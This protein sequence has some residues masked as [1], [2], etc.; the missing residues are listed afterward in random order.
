MSN[1]F[2]SK[3]SAHCMFVQW[4]PKSLQGWCYSKTLHVQ[5]VYLV[6]KT[7]KWQTLFRTSINFKTNKMS[8]QFKLLCLK[9]GNGL[10]VSSSNNEMVDTECL[11]T[12]LITK[13]SKEWKCAVLSTLNLERVALSATSSAHRCV[14]LEIG[15]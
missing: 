13:M 14:F 3:F 8:E 6:S 10:I 7:I 9:T 2:P 12:W 11:R 1:F 5:S 15:W 4:G